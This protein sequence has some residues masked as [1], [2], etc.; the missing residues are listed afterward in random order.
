MG[1]DALG[2]AVRPVGEIENYHAHIYFEGD[3][4]RPAIDVLRDRIAE[5]FSVQILGMIEKSI[6]LHPSPMLVVAFMPEVFDRLVPWLMLNNNGLSILVHPNTDNALGDHLDN[7][8][9]IGP[10][11]AFR[12]VEDIPAEVRPATS[13]KALGRS[14]PAVTVNTSPTL[15]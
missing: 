15:A 6:G 12:P 13:L 1:K 8:I 4:G 14:H 5:R 11:L 9:W 3:T 7:A 2:G 10:P